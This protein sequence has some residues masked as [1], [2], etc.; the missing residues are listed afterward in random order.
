MKNAPLKIL[1]QTDGT[2]ATMYLYGY[3]G[4][5]YDWWPEKEEE[6]ITDVSF[7]KALQKFEKDGIGTVHV[8]INSPGG[9]TQHMD[10]IIA[11]MQSSKMTVHTWVDGMAASAAADIFLAAKKENRHMAKNAKIMIHDARMY[12]YGNAKHLR[13]VADTLDKFAEAAIAQMAADTG[14]GEGDIREKYYDGEDHWFTAKECAELGFIS[15][16]EEYEVEK[17]PDGVEK[18]THAD[19]RKL[20]RE[21]GHTETD[22]N[23]F[24]RLFPGFFKLKP[25]KAENRLQMNLDDFKKDLGTENL[26]EEKVIG[27][28]KEKGYRVEKATPAPPAPPAPDADGDGNTDIA[29]TIKAAVTEATKDLADQ[30]KNLKVEVEK[31]GNA[32]GS[33]GPSGNPTPNDPASGA[34]GGADKGLEEELVKMND[35]EFVSASVF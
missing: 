31:F 12:A 8:R 5:D 13:T 1:T 32:P 21:H 4:Q 19:L 27:I 9:S 6:T 15:K 23:F 35:E 34:E 33:T 20:F 29:A 7:L 18:M 25:P 28:L 24:K 17:M 22:F 2:E 3:I 26:P 30:V 11:L 10:G 14:M 16:V